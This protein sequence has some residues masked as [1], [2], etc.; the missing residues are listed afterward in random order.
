M[1]NLA[2]ADHQIAVCG[3]VITIRSCLIIVTDVHADR[4]YSVGFDF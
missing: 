1:K 4:H 3:V 2:V